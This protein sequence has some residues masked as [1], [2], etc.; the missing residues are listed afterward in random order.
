MVQSSS[1]ELATTYAAR[2]A[3]FPPPLSLPPLKSR[4]L[5]S[6]RAFPPSELFLQ[7]PRAPHHPFMPQELAFSP[8]LTFLR[9]LTQIFRSQRTPIAPPI[10]TSYLATTYDVPVR[11]RR[12]G[13]FET[14][15]LISSSLVARRRGSL[16][17]LVLCDLRNVLRCIHAIVSLPLGV[18]A[19]PSW[20]YSSLDVPAFARLWRPFLPSRL[21]TTVQRRWAGP[22]HVWRVFPRADRSDRSLRR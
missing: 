7:S 8:V 9:R 15:F 6:C 20:P 2:S 14:P 4:V 13:S 11:S 12:L 3:V 22:C 21:S 1:V 5:K 18:S 10:F 16:S 19:T 17:Q